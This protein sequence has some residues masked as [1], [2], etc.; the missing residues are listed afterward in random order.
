MYIFNIYILPSATLGHQC[1]P[2]S[3]S[4]LCPSK[5]GCINVMNFLLFKVKPDIDMTWRLWDY[6]DVFTSLVLLLYLSFSLS[7]RHP[8]A[9]SLQSWVPTV[10]NPPSVPISV[11]IRK[12]TSTAPQT[13]RQQRSLKA[14][15]VWQASAFL[16]SQNTWLNQFNYPPRAQLLNTVLLMEQVSLRGRLPKFECIE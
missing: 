13:Q 7:C 3:P 14:T 9:H 12:V 11:T 10:S 5:G 8:S 15:I 2:F 4:C 16:K 6:L 1:F